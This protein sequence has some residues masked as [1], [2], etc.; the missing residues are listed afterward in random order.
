MCRRA[1][2][3]GSFPRPDHRPT[4]SRPDRRDR[5]PTRA[6]RPR[7]RPRESRPRDRRARARRH[8]G[9]AASGRIH[10]SQP[11]H[12]AGPAID[13]WTRH[14]GC[15]AWRIVDQR[16]ALERFPGAVGIGLALRHRD[17][18]AAVIFGGADVVLPVHRRR[19]DTDPARPRDAQ[20][21]GR[22]DER[23]GPHARTDTAADVPTDGPADPRTDTAPDDPTYGPTGSAAHRDTN[24]GANGAAAHSC[25]D[26]AADG[27]A[28]RAAHAAAHAQA[29]AG[30]DAAARSPRGQGSAPVPDQAR[31]PARPRQ[32][33]WGL[34][35]TLFEQA[36]RRG[37]G[38]RS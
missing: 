5:Q 35:T 31:D 1:C 23:A 13:R 32:G 19:P 14:V 24:P 11:G 22:A 3:I 10:Q 4:R 25:P 2:T 21:P 15:R 38:Q 7:P 37:Q 26:G 34:G 28:D 29:D 6:P 30:G 33:G 8:R 36:Q 17:R 18:P 12:R 16:R 20:H 27:P 9:A